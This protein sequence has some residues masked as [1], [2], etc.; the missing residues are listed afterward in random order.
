MSDQDYLP[1]DS[2]DP[3][4]GEYSGNFDFEPDFER[5]VFLTGDDS[6]WADVSGLPSFEPDIESA[7]NLLEDIAG[8][9]VFDPDF[10]Q[11]NPDEFPS[12]PPEFDYG[13]DNTRGPFFDDEQVQKW[14]DESGLRGTAIV[15]YDEEQDEFWID[16]DTN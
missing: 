15:Y 14:L 16:V 12:I 5:R 4:S 3:S 8:S 11:R 9:G 2:Y 10:N 6:V 1:E 13:G 7:A